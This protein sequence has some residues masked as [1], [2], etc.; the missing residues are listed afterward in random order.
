MIAE[1]CQLECIHSI[2]NVGLSWCVKIQCMYLLYTSNA[3]VLW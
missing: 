3:I 1:I 2:C